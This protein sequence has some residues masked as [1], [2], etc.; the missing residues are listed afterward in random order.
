MNV[1]FSGNDVHTIGNQTAA[2][3][4]GFI[5]TDVYGCCG[6]TAYTGNIQIT[7]NTIQCVADGNNC[8]LLVGN[9]TIA[10]GNTITATGWATGINVAGSSAKVTNNTINIGNGTGI[11]LQPFVDAVT[12]ASNKLSGKGRFGISAGTPPRA[13]GGGEI[14]N[15]TITGFAIPIDAPGERPSRGR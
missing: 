10:S 3:P 15:N 6:Y 4:W 1:L 14:Y 11:F 8:L 2:S 7:N 5:V 12:V 9:G 13:G